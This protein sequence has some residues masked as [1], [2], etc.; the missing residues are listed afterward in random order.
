MSEPT[1]SPAK[2][3]RLTSPVVFLMCLGFA[4]WIGFA[5]WQA[6]INNFAREAAGFTGADNA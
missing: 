1:H 5:S 3:S 2:A 6:L 4:N